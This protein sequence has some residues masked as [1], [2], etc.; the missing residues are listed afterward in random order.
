[1]TSEWRTIPASEY[2]INVVDGTHDSPKQVETGRYLITSK[3]LDEYEL[4]FMNAYKISED[5]YKKVIARSKVEQWDILFSMIGTIGRIYQETNIETDYAI[6]NVGLFRLGGNKQKSDWLKFYLKTAKVQ[7][8]VQ[9]RLRGSTQGYIPLG[10]LRD[11][12]II[13]PPIDKQNAIIG[14]EIMSYIEAAYEN[15]I[16]EMIRDTLG[17]SYIYGPDVARD[18]SDPLYL[19]ELLPALRRINPK[20]PKS[21]LSEAVGKLRDF[22]SGDLLQKNRLFMEYLQNGISVNYYDKGEQRA[23][24]VY[25]ADFQ[26]I[27]RNS[28]TVANQWTISENSTKRPDVIIFLNGLPVVVF[29]LKSPSREETDASE[30]Y[31][32]LRNYM[33]E[34]PSLFIYNAF[35]VMSDQA[36]TK[37]GTITAGEDRFMEWKTAD[38]SYENTQFAQFDTFIEGMFDKAR[39]LDIIDL[40]ANAEK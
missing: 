18:Y 24:L 9:S 36:T 30:A 1:M 39:L 33:H 11:M 29:E 28:F 34:I 32:Q 14:E 4:D 13:V 12:P 27:E 19:G 7:E 26:D 38:G 2:C 35:L 31:L 10:A 3:H 17:Y 37:A 6:K 23:A 25:L 8:Y 15:A 5:D 16:I 20:L 40:S 22:G 21:A